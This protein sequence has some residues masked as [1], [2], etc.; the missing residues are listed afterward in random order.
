LNKQIAL[1][2]LCAALL[3]A[4]AA[5]ASTV[6]ATSLASGTYTVTVVKI[7]DNKHIYVTLPDGTQTMLTAG[8]DSVDFT[9]V[10]ENDQ[11][12][13]SIDKGDVLVYLDL[14]THQ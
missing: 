4:P 6:D 13:L 11:L 10:K 8:R 7:I 14:T 2:G 12:K 3:A 5:A 9:K 1:L